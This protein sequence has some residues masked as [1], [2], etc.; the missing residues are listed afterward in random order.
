M[1]VL[2]VYF[3]IAG[4]V[5]A[6]RRAPD[7]FSSNLA[8]CIINRYVGHMMVTHNLEPDDEAPTEESDSEEDLDSEDDEV[9]ND[10]DDD[11]GDGDNAISADYGL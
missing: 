9:S 7:L 10:E 11:P 2:F 6:L 8:D 3:A 4:L 5:C 1:H